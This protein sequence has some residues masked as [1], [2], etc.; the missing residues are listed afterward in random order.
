MK[1]KLFTEKKGQVKIIIIALILI[2]LLL[3]LVTFTNIQI[4][5]SF[6]EFQELGK[7]VDKSIDKY[8]AWRTGEQ[9]EEEKKG[10]TAKDKQFTTTYKKFVAFLND[11][12]SATNKPCTCKTQ[13]PQP[14]EGY[15]ITL[16]K[17]TAGGYRAIPKRIDQTDVS[18]IKGPYTF[19]ENKNTQFCF[20][21]D[22]AY[23]NLA[24]MELTFT[25]NKITF[26]KDEGSPLLHNSTK[27]SLTV[28]N[29]QKPE[30]TLCFISPNTK[31]T[32]LSQLPK[33]VL[34]KQCK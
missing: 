15:I 21:A 34:K 2:V 20:Y 14:S 5:K 22:K 19:Q 17:R 3:F 18:T 8:T 16:Q 29:L 12:S 25:K 4:P 27:G 28:V 32:I 24:A 30:G 11:C 7:D 10:Q 33:D 23:I 26:G 9:T 31:P 13:L 6:K 1:P